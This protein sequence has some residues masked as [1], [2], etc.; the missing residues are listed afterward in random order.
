M[1]GAIRIALQIFLLAMFLHFFGVPAVKKYFKR[2]VMV[3]KTT[4][5]TKGLPAPSISVS[6][7]S[8]GHPLPD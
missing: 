2:E 8:F 5:D 4:K 6:L 1:R 7:P 3:V